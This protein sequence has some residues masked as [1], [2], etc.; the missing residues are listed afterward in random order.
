MTWFSLPIQRGILKVQN[1][2]GPSFK[3]DRLFH[4]G[5]FYLTVGLREF[6]D[7]TLYFFS[8]SRLLKLNCYFSDEFFC[9]QM[10]HE[11]LSMNL[12]QHM[13]YM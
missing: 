3:N 12:L 4:D 8:A 6:S 9:A 7:T 1:H 10:C 13:N 5:L 2:L 11:F